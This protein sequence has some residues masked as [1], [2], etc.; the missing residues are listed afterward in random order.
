M[1]KIFNILFSNKNN[2]FIL[3]L[4][5]LSFVPFK[6]GTSFSWIITSLTTLFLLQNNSFQV[7]GTFFS[8]NKRTAR[9]KLWVFLSLLFILTVVFSWYF[10]NGEIHFGKLDNINFLDKLNIFHLFIPILLYFF[11]SK[12]IPVSATLLIFAT[13]SSKNTITHIIE[14]SLSAY[15]LSFVFG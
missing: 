7:L 9:W 3:F 1:N 2:I 13:F 15:F 12:K 4:I 5:V 10:Y 6:I 14:K 11:T 8:T